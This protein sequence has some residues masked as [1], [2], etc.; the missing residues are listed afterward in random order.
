MT[1]PEMILPGVYIEEHAE[2]LITAGPISIGTIGMV[3]TARQ[4][5]VGQIQVLGSYADALR[6]FGPYDAFTAPTVAG[7]PLTLIRA[8]ELAYNNGASTVMAV[9]VTTSAAKSA[10]HDVQGPTGTAA[11]L[12]ALGPGIWGDN[13][14][15][16]I[17]T[18]DASRM[19]VRLLYPA[20]NPTVQ[21]AYTVTSGND[22][23]GQIT[24]TPSALVVASAGAHAGEKPSAIAQT[25]FAGGVDGNDVTDA[26]YETGLGLLLTADA[27]IIVAAG[28]GSPGVRDALRDHVKL[29][30]TDKYARERI[31][32]FGPDTPVN[33]TNVATIQPGVSDGR[34]IVAVPGIQTVDAVTGVPVT[35]RSSYSAAAVAGLL[36]ASDPQVSLTHQEVSGTGLETAFTADQLEQLVLH[37]F[38]ALEVDQTGTTRVVKGISTDPGAFTQITARR[39]VDYARMGVRAS[40]E[41]YIGL[42]NDDRVR[43]A[44]KGSI[45]GFLANMVDN[46]Q[47]ETYDLDVSA[48]RAQEIQGIAVVTMTLQPTFSI[49]YIQVV[50]YLQ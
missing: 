28:Q 48:T 18:V 23:V 26:D 36:G 8:L 49:D 31:A 46:E 9:R 14:A 32:V 40:A 1:M 17:D 45:N 38:L 12:T 33:T 4:G 22:L 44:M 13:I 39:I 43:Q 30:S 19:I 50:M 42:L 16:K 20:A 35:L 5:P 11:V 24:N 21:E 29:A 41:P 6:V 2:A 7:H 37:Q 15:I 47:L 10:T 34:M 25:N 27:Q 3:G